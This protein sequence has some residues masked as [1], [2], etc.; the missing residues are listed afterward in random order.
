MQFATHVE[1][2]LSTP[3]LNFQIKPQS[4]NGYLLEKEALNYLW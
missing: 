4:L 3:P 2:K 1:F